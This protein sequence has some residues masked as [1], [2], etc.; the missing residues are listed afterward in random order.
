MKSTLWAVAM[1]ITGQ[2]I[3]AISR[4]K[5]IL[6][7][8]VPL[9]INFLTA[10]INPDGGFRGRGKK[11]D[12]YYTAFGLEALL[13][14]GGSFS[15]K[16]IF[17]YL[18]RFVK[19]QPLDLIHLA[20]LIRCYT[21]LADDKIKNDLRCKF[22]NTLKKF[23][24][25]DGGY[26]NNTSVENGTVYG[27]FFALA[28]CQNLQIDLSEQ[29]KVIES[30]QALSNSDGSFSNDQK[31]QTGSTNAT[32]A[33]MMILHHLDQPANKK[34]A[35]WLLAQCF[36]SAGFLAMPKAPIPDLLSTATAIHALATTGFE[37]DTIKDKCLDYI[38]SLW[39]SK[40]GFYGNWTD[41]ILDCEYTYY[42][43]LALGNLA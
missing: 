13:A 35:E 36:S 40:G 7:D 24:S 5:K 33:A 8:S 6:N 31:I 12:L 10:S 20:S 41:S 17:N 30:I 19:N 3:R 39:C 11:S 16:K 21:D 4:S 18:Q 14:L 43:L 1:T 28:A 9:V 23:R 29:A 15:R 42:G 25:A 22:I 27:C 26:A 32:A 37:I 34:T 2:M 38:D